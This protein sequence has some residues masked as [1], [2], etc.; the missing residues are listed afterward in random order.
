VPVSKEHALV[1]TSGAADRIGPADLHTHS[2]GHWGNRVIS[3]VGAVGHADL[4]DGH[5]LAVDHRGEQG[6][7][8]WR[9]STRRARPCRLR[10]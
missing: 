10:R 5:A 7:L 2:R 1:I 6:D 3:L 9:R 4:G 8:R